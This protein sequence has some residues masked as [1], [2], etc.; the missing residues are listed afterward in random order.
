MVK[1][2]ALT[3]P[4]RFMVL[5]DVIPAVVDTVRLPVVS[6]VVPALAVRLP[7]DT[8]PPKFMSALDVRLAALVT[9]T[10]PV[11]SSVCRHWLSGCL[12]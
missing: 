1:V 9:V 3:V 11:A 7:T 8:V 4:P 6:S 5:P 2:P 10:A 12:R